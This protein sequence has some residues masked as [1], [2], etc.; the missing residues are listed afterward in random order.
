MGENFF[1]VVAVVSLTIRRYAFQ[2]H[3]H[4]VFTVF[5]FVFYLLFFSI[6]FRFL[7]TPNLPTPMSL[8]GSGRP[9]EE[10]ERA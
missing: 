9:Q 10:A 8:I 3:F 1:F 4:V 5:F 2:R 6:F 7:S